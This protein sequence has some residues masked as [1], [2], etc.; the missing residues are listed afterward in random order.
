[1]V[2]SKQVAG[3]SHGLMFSRFKASAFLALVG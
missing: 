3:L 2:M 1:M